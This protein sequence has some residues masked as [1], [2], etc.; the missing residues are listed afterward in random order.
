M[1]TFARFRSFVARRR[2]PL[3]I[4]LLDFLAAFSRPKRTTVNNVNDLIKE[5]QAYVSG[6]ATEFLGEIEITLRLV[7]IPKS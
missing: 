2:R 1:T 7:R 5:P 3:Q 6:D 4:A